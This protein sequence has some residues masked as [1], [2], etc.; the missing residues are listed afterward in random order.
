M[1]TPETAAFEDEFT[2]EFMKSTKEVEDGYYLF[3]SKTDGYTM[4]FPVN[5]TLNKGLY[6]RQKEYRESVGFSEKYDENNSSFSSHIRYEKRKITERIDANLSLVSSYVGYEG[7]YE[8]FNHD[9][10]TYY[11]ATDVDHVSDS[12]IVY[13]FFSYIKSDDSHQG[14]SVIYDVT[15]KAA[16]IGCDIDLEKEEEKALTLMKSFEFND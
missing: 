10:K 9:N 3:E 5:A 6:Y 15:C 11:Y 4:W 2:R 13:S 1:S 12:Y 8:E 16:D 14:I 7:E